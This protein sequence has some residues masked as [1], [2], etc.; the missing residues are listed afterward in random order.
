MEQDLM[1]VRKELTGVV[2]RNLERKKEKEGGGI[3]D[4]ELGADKVKSNR[5]Q[6]NVL[7]HIEDMR[8]YDVPL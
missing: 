7:D 2:E 3:Q 4:V 1:A 8:E 6:E 5:L